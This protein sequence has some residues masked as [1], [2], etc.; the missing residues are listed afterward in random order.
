MLSLRPRNDPCEARSPTCEEERDAGADRHMTR[1]VLTA[2]GAISAGDKY[3]VR[4]GG[5]PDALRPVTYGGLFA[6]P[7]TMDLLVLFVSAARDG[8]RLR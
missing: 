7:D 6:W 4:P 2:L 5:T 3:D 8:G 1:A